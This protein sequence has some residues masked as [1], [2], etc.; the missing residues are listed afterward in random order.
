MSQAPRLTDI[1]TTWEEYQQQ[2][3]VFSL[4]GST[5]SPHHAVVAAHFDDQDI[6]RVSTQNQVTKN[7]PMF[8]VDNNVECSNVILTLIGTDAVFSSGGFNLQL[9]EQEREARKGFPIPFEK[10]FDESGHQFTVS[11]AWTYATTQSVLSA[12]REVTL[13]SK[14]CAAELSSSQ[15]SALLA[16][17]DERMPGVPRIAMRLMAEMAAVLGER[18]VRA[19]E[20]LLKQKSAYAELI[21]ATEVEV[22]IDGEL[23]SLFQ[24]DGDYM[25]INRDGTKYLPF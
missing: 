15:D 14:S 16:Y 5:M 18:L 1:P 21:I 4:P 24:F 8:R 12:A 7:S 11:R 13:D 20:D 22:P 6:Y 3:A 2:K 17:I 10:T 23:F 19:L 25:Y 9:E